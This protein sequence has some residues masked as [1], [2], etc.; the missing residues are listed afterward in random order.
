MAISQQAHPVQIGA[1]GKTC[2]HAGQNHYAY[3]WIAAGVLQGSGQLGNQP[4]VKSVVHLRAVEAKF[5]DAGMVG[6]LYGVAHGEKS[7]LGSKPGHLNH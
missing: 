2:A 3:R 6:N 7:V 4:V 5:A 1:G